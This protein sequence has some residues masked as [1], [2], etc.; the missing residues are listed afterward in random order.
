MNLGDFRQVTG[1]KQGCKINLIV[2]DREPSRMGHAMLD[3][4]GG[5]VDLQLAGI[6]SRGI[7]GQLL[8]SGLNGVTSGLSLLSVTRTV[9]INSTALLPSE[10]GV[11]RPSVGPSDRAIPF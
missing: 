10:M 6:S 3:R 7:V 5:F 11:G 8:P 9:V 2:V 4:Y 1:R